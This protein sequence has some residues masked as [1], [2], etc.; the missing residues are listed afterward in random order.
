MF[1]EKVPASPV[2]GCGFAAPDYNRRA[3]LIAETGLSYV[4]GVYAEVRFAAAF[5]ALIA[6]RAGSVLAE[7]PGRQTG[8]SRLAGQPEACQR[9]CGHAEAEPFESLAPC[10][11]LGHTFRQLIEF[12]IHSLSSF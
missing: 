11:R 1:R 6:G 8:L 2:R 4:L 5:A 7:R 10:Y 9:H 3:D 12:V